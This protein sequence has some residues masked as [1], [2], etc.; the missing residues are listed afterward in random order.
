MSLCKHFALFNNPSLA[1]I[2][3]EYVHS[4]MSLNS[5]FSLILNVKRVLLY[6]CTMHAII[7]LPLFAQYRLNHD[8]P[9]NVLVR[10]P[11]AF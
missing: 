1:F 7:V 11:A 9:Q 6:V 2:A 5:I 4:E 10:N 8:T 3:L